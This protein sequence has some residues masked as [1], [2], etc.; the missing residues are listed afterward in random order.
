MHVLMSVQMHVHANLA[1]DMQDVKRGQ[2]D[3]RQ[4]IERFAVSSQESPQDASQLR[5][6]VLNI[7]SQVKEVKDV[8]DILVHGNNNPGVLELFLQEGQ[9]V[10]TGT[11]IHG[12]ALKNEFT[13][14]GSA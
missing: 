12:Y 10:G 13:F 8:M 14:S 9:L 5:G 7:L 11:W 4:E 6:I 2:S 3:I 1:N